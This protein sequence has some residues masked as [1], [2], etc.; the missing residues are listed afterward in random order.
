MELKDVITNEMKEKV[1]STDSSISKEEIT[2]ILY[3]FFDEVVERKRRNVVEGGL[4]AG[5]VAAKDGFAAKI[6]EGDGKCSHF[7]TSIN[8]VKYLNGDDFFIT[9]KGIGNTKLYRDALN[10]LFIKCIESRIVAGDREL[11]MS[12]NSNKGALS[13]FQLD[14][15]QS[16]ADS[17]KLLID[18]DILDD[19]NLGLR[20]GQIDLKIDKWDDEQ[21]KLLTDA[22]N[23][24]RSRMIPNNY[25]R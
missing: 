6:N 2:N 8:L 23:T 20:V 3:Y 22:I 14:L 7:S 24:E 17:C 15:L 16:I 21:Y 12:F 19:V 9:D 10:E 13:E 1:Y 18:N 5:L 25:Q 11:L 4:L